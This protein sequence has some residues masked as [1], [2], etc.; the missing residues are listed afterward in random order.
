MIY[1]SN[2]LKIP[3][4]FFP[5][6]TLRIL[7]TASEVEHQAL[8]I[9][10]AHTHLEILNVLTRHHGKQVTPTQAWVWI[11]TR[12]QLTE[13]SILITELLVFAKATIH[14]CSIPLITE[15]SFNV[16][17]T[18]RR[19]KAYMLQILHVLQ[20]N[21]NVNPVHVECVKPVCNI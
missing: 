21:G 10:P 9:V 13:T 1:T 12:I 8:F 2:N 20:E 18:F 7:K 17:K 19:G 16:H 14:S 3:K 6:Q 4:H 11:V 15:R 5:P